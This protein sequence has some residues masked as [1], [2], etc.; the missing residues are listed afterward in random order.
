MRIINI[1]IALTASLLAGCATTT[2]EVT[3]DPCSVNLEAPLRAAMLSATNRLANGCE[4]HY[5]RYFDDLIDIAVD[6]PKA[7]NKSAFSDF[8]VSLSEQ[9]AISLRQAKNLYNSYFGVKFVALSGD[10][11]TGSEVCPVKKKVLSEMR[12]ELLKKETGLIKASDDASS[13]HRADL[14]L[15]ELEILLGATCMAYSR[16][17]SSQ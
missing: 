4:S 6:D 2:T 11:N 8:L 5:E 14:L 10:Y 16:G 9:G 3:T 1:F 7:D 15:N 17:A 12:L 13:Y